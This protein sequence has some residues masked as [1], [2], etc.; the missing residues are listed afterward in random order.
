MFLSALELRNIIESS[1]LPK[2][3][4]CSLSQDLSM[5]VKVYSD[6]VTD[7]V[8][9]D[10]SG[11]DARHLNGHREISELIVDLRSQ[12]DQKTSKQTLHPDRKAF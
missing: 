12:I 5:R 1:F 8:D 11:I 7:Q 3:C 9:L 6:R 10:M 4:L 2:R